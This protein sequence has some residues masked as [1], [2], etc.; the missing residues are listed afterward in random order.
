VNR[1]ASCAPG[2]AGRCAGIA[3]ALAG[4]GLLGLLA[5]AAAAA[6]GIGGS[7]KVF[8]VQRRV[9]YQS[10]VYEQT[11]VMTGAAGEVRLGRLSLSVGGSMGT[12]AGDGSATNQDV[13][14]RTTAVALRV[15][16]A[17]ALSLGGQVEARRFDA[18]AGV[19]SWRLIGVTARAEPGLGLPGLRGFAEATFLPASS[20]A[21]GPKIKTALQAAVGTSLTLGGVARIALAYRFERYDVEGTTSSAE[22]YEQF[23]GVVAEVGIRL[24]R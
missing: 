24:G 11:G 4:A 1:P 10:A 17:P 22:R 23:R 2:R 9:S 13:K 6:Q 3:R 14:V 7:G 5:P 20:V 19:V 21:N 18:G 16:L 12:L 8:N 15:A